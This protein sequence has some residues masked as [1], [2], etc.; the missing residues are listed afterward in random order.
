MNDLKIFDNTEFGKIRAEEING[1]FYAAGVDVARALGYAK[2]DKAVTDHCKAP[3][4][5]G[6]IDSLGR[7][8]ETNMIPE[9]D[10]YRL[11]VKAADQN[12]NPDI[13]KKAARFEAWIFEDVLPSIR[14]HGA[15]VTSEKME[16]ILNDP[17]NLVRLF[18]SLREEN[19]QLQLQIENDRAKVLLANAVTT[20]R[21]T[22]LVG[23]LAKILKGNGLEIGQNRLFE[24]LRERGFLIKRRGASFNSPTQR[25]MRLG[26]FSIRETAT[27]HPD[28][29]VSISKTVKVTGKG[30]IYFA[31]LFLG[32]P[33]LSLVSNQLDFPDFL[34]D[35]ND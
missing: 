21:C 13:Q 18:K 29:H 8:Q 25:S 5:W 17:Q 1:K 15:Y 30:Q 35:S 23:E 3:L 14:R 20:S 28:G 7:T 9:G 19:R 16:E 26:I 22:I 32:K 31:N 4:S 12:R 10:I 11:I 6:V 27:L 24:I 33:K 34:D 2:P